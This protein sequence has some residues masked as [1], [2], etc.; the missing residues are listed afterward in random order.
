VSIVARTKPRP[1]WGEVA[2]YAAKFESDGFDKMGTTMN[3]MFLQSLVGADRAL[4]ISV[5]I[6]KQDAGRDVQVTIDPVR[7]GSPQMT[8]EEWR[9]FVLR[10][11]GSIP[12][13]RS[14]ATNKASTSG[15]RIYRDAPVRH[16]FLRRPLAA[17]SRVE[18]WLPGS[19]SSSSPM[20]RP[21]GST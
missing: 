2:V 13:P 20:I 8:Q 7:A 1:T 9:E 5:P 12:T 15:V 14:C 10:T 19:N 21:P 3:R 18:C 6:G 11:A 16:E 4:Q 17:R